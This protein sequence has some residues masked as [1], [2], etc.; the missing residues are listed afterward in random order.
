MP[1]KQVSNTHAQ[2]IVCN[3]CSVAIIAEYDTLTKNATLYDFEPYISN[4]KAKHRHP[5]DARTRAKVQERVATEKRLLED[6]D[7][8]DF[9]IYRFYR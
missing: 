2:A 1:V 9:I 7:P 8:D 6:R 5:C 4:I 3:E